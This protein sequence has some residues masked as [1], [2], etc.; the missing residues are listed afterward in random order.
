MFFVFWCVCVCVCVCVWLVCC[1]AWIALAQ[2]ETCR[3]QPRHLTAKEAAN[4]IT[5]DS[6]SDEN[7]LYRSARDSE[8]EETG[9]SLPRVWCDAI[10][11]GGGGGGGGGGSL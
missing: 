8:E 1:S 5:K 6:D 2:R 9:E 10:E 3:K 4:E 11:M 7:D